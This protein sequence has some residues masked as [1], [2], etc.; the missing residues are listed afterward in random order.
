GLR[1]ADCQAAHKPKAGRKPASRLAPLA[2]TICLIRKIVKVC[3]PVPPIL[4]ED[5]LSHQEFLMPRLESE[6]HRSP[7][8]RV[9]TSADDLAETLSTVA[10]GLER[11][12]LELAGPA[13]AA[14]ASPGSPAEAVA[15]ASERQRPFPPRAVPSQRSSSQKKRHV[16]SR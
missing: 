2:V 1:P 11:H 5:P 14:S 10:C 13:T 16:W 6:Q 4:R 9:A 15:N 8:P 7:D 3:Q 12:V